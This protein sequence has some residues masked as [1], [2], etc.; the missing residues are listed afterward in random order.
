MAICLANACDE[1]S[2]VTPEYGKECLFSPYTVKQRRYRYATI[3]WFHGDLPQ[4]DCLSGLNSVHKKLSLSHAFFGDNNRPIH[5]W[6][7]HLEEH[8]VF[9]TLIPEHIWHWR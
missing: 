5:Q 1:V 3:D 9:G 6:L 7:N 4:Q 2:I 8:P